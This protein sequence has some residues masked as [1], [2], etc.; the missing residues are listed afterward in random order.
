MFFARLTKRKAAPKS[1]FTFQT[2]TRVGYF[3]KFYDAIAPIAKFNVTDRFPGILFVSRSSVPRYSHLGKC[4]DESIRSQF[5]FYR[6]RQTVSPTLCRCRSASGHLR[7][8]SRSR[9]FPKLAFH[10]ALLRKHPHRCRSPPPDTC[11][12]EYERSIK[13]RKASSS[14]RRDYLFRFNVISITRLGAK[15][16]YLASLDRNLIFNLTYFY[17]S[18]TRVIIISSFILSASNIRDRDALDSKN[19]S[20]YGA[21]LNEV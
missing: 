8:P 12:I 7:D 20:H 16:E 21:K 11:L 15:F 17:T 13:S 18:C 4:D 14:R 5:R 19:S 3:V 10:K 9:G 1:K 6:R 2:S